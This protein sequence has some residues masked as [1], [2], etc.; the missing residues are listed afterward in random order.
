M[1]EQTGFFAEFGAF[2]T[3]AS[4]AASETIASVRELDRQL[5]TDEG[6]F[7]QTISAPS[8][9]ED[10]GQPAGGLDMQTLLLIGGAVVVGIV[11]FN[12]LK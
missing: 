12:A 8:G 11:A 9:G 3:D 4:Q 2:L 5:N 7:M 1:A 6:D 10:S